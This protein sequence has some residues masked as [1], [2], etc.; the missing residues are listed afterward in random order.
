MEAN[1]SREKKKEQLLDFIGEGIVPPNF[2]V[3]IAYD[4]INQKRNIEVINL[5]EVLKKKLNFSENQ[6]ETYYNQN[7]DTFID[8]YKSVKFVKLN[9]KNLTGNDEFNDL[10]FQ[11]IDEIDDLIVE[12]EN[13]DFILN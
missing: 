2:L 12:G 1:I 8:V 11:K 5:N 9:L 6:I 10:F 13:L 3:N 4:K 7:K